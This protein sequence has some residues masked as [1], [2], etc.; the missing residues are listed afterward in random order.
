MKALAIFS[1][2]VGGLELANVIGDFVV[3]HGGRTLATD[4]LGAVVALAA[5]AL[6][7][8]GVA[9]FRRGRT[10]SGVASKAAIFSVL[11]FGAIAAFHPFLAIAASVL[12][13]VF[14]LILL[15]FLLRGSATGDS[16]ATS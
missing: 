9:L 11:V 12:G 14:P 7:V 6:I 3:G 2:I 15:A 5:I 13:I 16:R 10:A 1:M 8:S 4:L